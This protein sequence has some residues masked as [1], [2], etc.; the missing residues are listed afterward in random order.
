MEGR[1]ETKEE[2]EEGKEEKRK[3]GPQAVG[4]SHSS[5]F[6]K[7]SCPTL[8]EQ[9]SISKCIEFHNAQFSAGPYP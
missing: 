6:S 3:E 8:S 5:S 9:N 4:N 2:G 1:Q 7:S